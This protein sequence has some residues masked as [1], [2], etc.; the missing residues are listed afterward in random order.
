MTQSE[1]VEILATIREQAQRAGDI[2][3][4]IGSFVSEGEVSKGMVDI[5][6]AIRSVMALLKEELRRNRIEVKLQLSSDLPEVH[7]AEIGIEQV[8]LNLVKNAI[9][10]MQDVP[11]AERRLRIAT[12]R[13]A[14]GRVM[15]SVSDSGRG[16]TATSGETY[17][18]PFVSTKKDG[19][20][21][22]LAICRSIISALGGRIS[23]RKARKAGTKVSFLLPSADEAMQDA[24]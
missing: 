24:A 19:M 9:E 10:A 4:H 5:N 18:E 2:L 17:F 3:R 20:G 21:M 14:G 7:A 11:A 1:L 12:S 23:M 6:D 16:F 8:V 22:G 13:R 15:V